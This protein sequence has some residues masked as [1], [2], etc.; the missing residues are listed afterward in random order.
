MIQAHFSGEPVRIESAQTC[1]NHRLI[2]RLSQRHENGGY[3]WTW[4]GQA[5]SGVLNLEALPSW[6]RLIFF[7]DTPEPWT[8]DGAAIACTTTVGDGTAP[9]NVQGERDDGLWNRMTFNNGGADRNPLDQTPG[10]TYSLEL[11]ANSGPGRQ[12]ICR[13]SDWVPVNGLPRLD[14]GFGALLV[15]RSYSAARMRHCISGRAI[16]PAIRRDYASFWA[17][18]DATQPGWNGKWAPI[19]GWFASYGMQY[20]AAA[21]GATVLAVG[22]SIMASNASS[23]GLSGFAMRACATLS[24]PDRP[25]SFFND[26]YVGR[27]SPEYCA[28]AI[29]DIEHLRPQA[30][31]I[32]TW[33]ENDGATQAG[34][35][36]GFAQAMAV[37]DFALRH[38]C[39]PI[40][41]TAAPVTKGNARAESFRQSNLAR[42]RAMVSRGFDVLDIDALWGTG[43]TPNL[44][45]SEFDSGDRTHQNDAGCVVAAQALVPILRRHLGI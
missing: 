16:D 12:P 7:N 13:F 26:G 43:E 24:T 30:V 4:E 5:L 6:V 29:W 8:L 10:Q 20:I 1:P 40:L 34:A 14:G 19:P 2:N 35:D 27:K 45:R 9:V 23:G 38:G 21:Q 18:G 41:L 11:P 36:L 37:A 22:D 39:S 32:S 17:R 44:Y 25:I 31:L 3:G 33:S 15:V 28:A 42:V